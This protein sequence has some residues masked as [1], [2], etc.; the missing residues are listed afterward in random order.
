[1]DSHSAGGVFGAPVSHSPQPSTAAPLP[2]RV[3]T[4]L[5]VPVLTFETG[6][7]LPLLRFYA[8]RQPDS[9]R[10]RLWEV[11]GTAHADTYLLVTGPRDLGNS[12][13]AAGI[14]IT[15]APIPGI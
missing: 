14:V 10:L 3:R 12:P 8:A 15:A 1:V 2:T 11:A 6:T 9:R 13:A 5:R 7:D 4:D